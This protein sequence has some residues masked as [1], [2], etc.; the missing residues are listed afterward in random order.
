MSPV[1]MEQRWERFIELTRDQPPWPRLVRAAGLFAQPGG[2]VDLGAGG[3]RD[4]SHL[5]RNRW[6]V[7]AVD[8]SPF[9]AS[10][11]RRMPRQRWLTVVTSRIED[12]APVACDLLNAQF[13]L[14]FV[15]PDRFD[16]TV[17]GL[18]DAVRPA[19]V[20]AATFFGP[21]D[22]WRTSDSGLTFRDLPQVTDL[23]REWEMIELSEV[24]EDG[25]TADGTPKHWHVF[26]VIARRPAGTG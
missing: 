8:A 13:S 9:S 26:H 18:L 11:L 6:R 1:S 23:F 16:R 4:T 21:R 17:G 15:P 7:T 19:G 5:L 22:E 12:Y 20:V 24:E 14:P 3:G 2:A 25:Q 10:A